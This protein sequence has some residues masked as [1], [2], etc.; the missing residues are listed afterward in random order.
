MTKKG[1]KLVALAA[2]FFAVM[3]GFLIMTGQECN[4]FAKAQSEQEART[5]VSRNYP[6]ESPLA[7]NI[8]ALN[9]DQ[10]ARI[11]TLLKRFRDLAQGIKELPNGYAIQL[12]NE[13]S[14]IRD[15]AECITLERQCCPFFDFALDAEPEVGYIWFALT[16]REGVKEVARVEF[17]VQ[18]PHTVTAATPRGGNSPL[19]CNE[20]ALTAAQR[21]R[22]GLLLKEFRADKKEVKELPNGY[23]IR[24]PCETSTIMDVAE[25]MTLVRSCSPYVG[26]TLQVGAEDGPVWLKLTGPEGVKQ[27]ARIE[28]GLDG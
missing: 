18:K 24:L 16:G 25:Y 7:C 28:F 12:A 13:A 10:R 19:V 9:A 27:Q 5:K 23:A 17:G 26:A 8:T 22:L 20:A 2:L 21:E 6:K 3:Q 1:F 15:L 4:V 11:Q 14:I